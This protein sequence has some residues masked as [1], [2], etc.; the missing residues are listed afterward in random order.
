M[1]PRCARG[2]ARL[3]VTVQ[4]LEKELG[5]VEVGGVGD[6][7]WEAAKQADEGGDRWLED[8]DGRRWEVDADWGRRRRQ[9]QLARL[10]LSW[11]P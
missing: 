10:P 3:P 8:V 7:R 5:A 9:W 4:R 6:R 11:W 1:C 2:H